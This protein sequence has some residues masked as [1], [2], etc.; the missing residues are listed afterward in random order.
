MPGFLAFSAV[1]TPREDAPVPTAWTNASTAP[2]VCSQI[3]SPSA[4]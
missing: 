4:W 3:S 2:C 1:A